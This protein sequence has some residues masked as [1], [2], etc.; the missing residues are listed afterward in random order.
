MTGCYEKGSSP[1]AHSGVVG[2]IVSDSTFTNCFSGTGGVCNH[3][4]TCGN[5][6]IGCFHR[7]HPKSPIFTCNWRGTRTSYAPSP[8]DP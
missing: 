8:Y 5:V 1:V 6:V 3:A 7:G 4:R 2:E